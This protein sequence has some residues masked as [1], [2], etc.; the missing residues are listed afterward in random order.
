M[1]GEIVMQYFDT[2]VFCE[3]GKFQKSIALD[4]QTIHNLLLGLRFRNRLRNSVLCLTLKWFSR[5]MFSIFEHGYRDRKDIYNPIV[6][7]FSSEYC[8]VQERVL[9]TNRTSNNSSP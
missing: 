9:K 8:S 2:D 3:A 1:L 5:R 4:I 6:K 7:G